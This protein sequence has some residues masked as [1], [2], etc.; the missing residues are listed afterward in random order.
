MNTPNAGKRNQDLLPTIFP[1][2]PAGGE[3]SVFFLPD[4]GGNTFYA[5]NLVFQLEP[6]RGAYGMRLDS[7]LLENLPG[8][9]LQGL[10]QRFAADLHASAFA[11]PFH[12]VGHSFAGILAFETARH[13]VMLGAEVGT[14]ALLDCG[15]PS[16]F[17]SGW[18]YRAV[19]AV[20]EA[21]R[22]FKIRQHDL[23]KK[24]VFGHP[25]DDPSVILSV[26][27]FVRM[28]LTKHP[29]SYRHIIRHLYRAMVDYEPGPYAG[30]LTL[31]RSM[32]RG[33]AAAPA[34]LGWGPYARGCVD[35]IRITGDHLDMVRDDRAAMAVA[36]RLDRILSAAEHRGQKTQ[37][38]TEI[39]ATAGL[40]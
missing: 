34:D 11:E 16:R 7:E 27:G 23:L 4:L 13:L 37:S 38:A 24:A 31:F 30:H 18:Y 10:A 14:L 33:F 36:E 19:G 40:T 15:L 1:L 22:E 21:V 35:V 32:N 9:T 2:R 6:G 39:A 12:L 8:C 20:V 29:E 28:D 3:G 5:K 26:P 17:Y 25:A